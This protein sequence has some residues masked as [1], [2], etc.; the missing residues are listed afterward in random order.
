M[1]VSIC[2]PTYNQALYVE[3]AI[4]SAFQQTLTPI[5]IIV[6]D[7]C[8]TDDTPQILQR[9]SLEIPILKI[10]SQPSNTGITFNTNTCLRQALGDFVVRLDSDDFLSPDYTEKLVGLLVQ[11]PAAGY[12]HANVQEIDQKDRPLQIRNLHRSTGFQTGDEAIRAAIKG[13][14][15]AANIIMFTREA[16]T[17]VN[18][19]TTQA[20]FAEDY[21]LSVSLAAAGYGNVYLNETLS[22]Y[23]VWLDTG[24]TRQRR[25]LAEIVG[26][27]TV[28]D[29]VL[30][31]AYAKRGWDLRELERSRTNFACRHADCLG[32]SSYTKDE[33]LQ[34]ADELRRLSSSDLSA[35]F[36]WLHLHGLGS[37]LGFFNNLKSAAK[38]KAKAIYYSGNKTTR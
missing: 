17:N 27:Y 21:H 25:K 24:K 31:P 32:W 7:D 29:D 6:A 23:R 35:C 14:R 36:I 37:V 9:L 13:Y 11:Y 38:A 10:I 34:L 22:F 12:A 3:K 20:N 4:R 26:L 28:F 18:F 30:G 19:I 33:K 8:S 2:I 1:K 5:E 15:V 16:L